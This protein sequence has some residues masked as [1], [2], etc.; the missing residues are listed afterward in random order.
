[1]KKSIVV[2]LITSLTLVQC[3][4]PYQYLPDEVEYEDFTKLCSVTLNDSIKY[5]FEEDNYIFEIKSDS[6]MIIQPINE[7]GFAVFYEKQ[8]TINL[9]EL[10]YIELSEIDG[11]KTTLFVVGSGVII[12]LAVG[13]IFLEISNWQPLKGFRF[14]VL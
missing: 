10:A 6:I 13:Y 12:F 5:R 14:G 8:D 7:I 2:I 1:M 11:L 3:Y 9:N 4:S